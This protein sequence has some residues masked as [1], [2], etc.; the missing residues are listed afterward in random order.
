MG[1]EDRD[2]KKAELGASGLVVS[3]IATVIG[4]FVKSLKKPKD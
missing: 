1:K 4:L 2:W 3:F